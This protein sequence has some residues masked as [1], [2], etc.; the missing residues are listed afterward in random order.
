MWYFIDMYDSWSVSQKIIQLATRNE[1]IWKKWIKAG[2]L[3]GYKA[4]IDPDQNVISTSQ[5]EVIIKN[6]PTGTMRKV[7]VKIGFTTKL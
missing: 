3:S 1:I 6:V 7:N 5:V 4:E 2:E